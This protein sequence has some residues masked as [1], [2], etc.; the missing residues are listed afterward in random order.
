MAEGGCRTTTASR[1][2]P[3][4][5][6]PIT[7]RTCS[8]TRRKRQKFQETFNQK[9][10]CTYEDWQ[11]VDWDVWQNIG[12]HFQRKK[13]EP[14]GDGVAD[15]DFYGIS[16]QA[17]VGYD[18]STMQVNAFIWQNGGSIWDETKAPEGQALGVVNSDIAVKSFDQYLSMLP[19]MPPVAK[20]G[21]MDIFVVQDLF[22]QGK[23]AAAIDWVGL[24]EPVLDPKT[25]KVSDKA[26]FGVAP[27]TKKAGRH[28]RPHR[29]YRWPALRAD[30][31][32]QPRGQRGR[33]RGGEV[34]AKPGDAEEV[35]RQ[36]RPVGPA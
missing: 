14:L 24:G 18:F 17:G 9:L 20:T 23:V 26:A 12:K 15:D 25:S 28:D 31:L 1:S 29:Q 22:M 33:A 7:A 16:Y 3:T 36:R 30:H 27:G 35:R 2:S 11:Q 13:G 6:S 10:P 21:Q 5:T 19:Y 32:E 34:V 4:P 8:A